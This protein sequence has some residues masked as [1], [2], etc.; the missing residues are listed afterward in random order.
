MKGTDNP[1]EPAG[2]E[3]IL[4][5]EREE[6][7][8]TLIINR[9]EKRNS[10]NPEV[11]IRL[12]DTLQSLK[13]DPGIRV[14]V[15]RGVGEE[16]FSS[17][18]DIGRIAAGAPREETSDDPLDYGMDSV[19][20][21]P[22]PVIAMIYGFAIGAG[23]ELALSCDLRI[24]ADTAKLGITPAKLGIVYRH[25]GI[26]KFMDLVGPSQTK[27]LFYTGRIIDAQRAKE[28]GLVNHVFPAAELHSKTYQL[29]REIADNAP[30]SIS[31]TKTIISKLLNCQIPSRE[32]AAEMEELRI[33]SMQSEDLKEGQRAFMEKRK[34]KFVGR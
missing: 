9:P 25:V 33:S 22:H 23:L 31:G 12:G 24:A 11:L 17:G 14:I 18:F 8:C 34:P 19:V 7:V 29:A 27:E 16:A 32:D 4:L 20:S 30:L 1:S 5:V 26:Q 6:R 2:T 13:H 3:E 28:I 15:I 21:Y 10:L